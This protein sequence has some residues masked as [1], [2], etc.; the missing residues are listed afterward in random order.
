MLAHRQQ[1]DLDYVA[2]ELELALQNNWTVIPVLVD[3]ASLPDRLQLPPAIRALPDCQAAQLRQTN[4]DDD[5]ADLTARL[6]E[7]HHAARPTEI[8]LRQETSGTVPVS[9]RPAKSPSADPEE[10]TAP[11]LT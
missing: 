5:I 4:L 6:N 7:I 10:S 11:V 1:G 9:R 3:N 2:K 8:E